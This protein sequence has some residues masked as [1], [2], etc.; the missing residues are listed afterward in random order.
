MNELTPQTLLVLVPLLPLV[1]AVLTVALGRLL[2][3]HAHLP[4][5]AAIAAAF[6]VAGMLLT[7][8]V[9]EVGDHAGHGTPAHAVEM[10]TT[11]W[12][13]ASVPDAAAAGEAGSGGRAF[14]V[15]ITLRL[16]PLTACLLVIITG[17]GLLVAVYSIGYMHGDPGYP[18]FFALVSAFV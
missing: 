1:G 8:I 4:A 17:V 2:G 16:D 18:R 5:V 10:T 12:Q 14:S 6:V 15:P 9:K 7:G 11:L 3:R 13:W